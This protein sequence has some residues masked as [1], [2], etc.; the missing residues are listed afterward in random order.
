MTETK[1]RSWGLITLIT[2][3]LIIMGLLSL[4]DFEWTL[5]L[6]RHRID[7]LGAF[8][9]RTM[10]EG[11]V[12][13]G[14]DPG[15]LV[16]LVPTIGYFL[17]LSSAR[18]SSHKR[19]LPYLGFIFFSSLVTGLGLVHS[20][21]WMVGRARP[22]LII[23]KGIPFTHWFE[24]GPLHVSDGIFFG[25]IP[26]G[27]TATV[28]LMITI[29]YI[30]A[31]DP[32]HSLR[33]KLLGWGWGILVMIYASLMVIG[34]SM[35]L[36]HWLT[37]SV[38]IILLDWIVIH[39]IYFRVLKIPRQVAVINATGEYP[40]TARYWELKLLWRLLVITLAVMATVIGIKSVIFQ[41]M[42]ALILMLIP[43]LPTIY[44]M[45]NNLLNIYAEKTACFNNDTPTQ[46]I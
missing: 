21:K 5:Y 39:L 16:M 15:I 37:D 32:A 40:V 6:S 17:V 8:M 2:I 44:F 27:H 13:G 20:L 9:R 34:R 45:W 18:F 22:Y 46:P 36:H 42:P 26:S 10:F 19:W 12:F 28:I 4:V 33:T 35:T 24:F 7:W 30:L 23:K 1:P 41:E 25:S 14:S 31:G 43:A 11:G 29:S 38:G 3:S